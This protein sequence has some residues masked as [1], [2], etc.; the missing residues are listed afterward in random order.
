MRRAEWRAWFIPA[1]EG[2][3]VYPGGMHERLIASRARGVLQN[4][5]W[6]HAGQRPLTGSLKVTREDGLLVVVR[7]KPI[8]RLGLGPIWQASG[9]VP[10]ML[11]A[12]LSLAN[13]TDVQISQYLGHANSLSLNRLRDGESFLDSESLAKAR[14]VR[15]EGA[16]APESAL[17]AHRRRGAA[18]PDRNREE[19]RV[20]R[21]VHAGEERSR[22]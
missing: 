16:R 22:K 6:A 4:Q 7:Q 15:G 12:L 9:I 3:H 21:S 5:Q 19:P 18:A 20:E 11:A 1:L 2:V 17:G 14:P 13:Q 8:R 10:P